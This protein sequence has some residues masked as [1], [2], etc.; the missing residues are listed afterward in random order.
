MPG[1]R[2]PY[3]TPYIVEP[4]RAIASGASKRIVMVFAAQTGKTEAMLDVAGHRLDQ[5]PGPI[6]YVGPNKQFL[7]EQFEPRVMALLDEAPTL[8]SKVARG[9][10]MTKTRKVI[11]GVP[12]RLAHAGSSTALKS[13]PAVLALIDEYDEM[14][15][16]VNQ[17]GGPLG[18]VERR[19]DTYAEFV[20]VVTSTPKKGRVEF[21]KDERSGLSFWDIAPTDDI[22]SPI[23]QLFQQGTRHHWCWPCPH[24]R[25]Y[26]VPRSALLRYPE[27]VTP[28]RAAKSAY[29]EC[30]N[31][32][33]EIFDRHK[34]GMNERGRYV[35]P[36]QKVDEDGNVTGSA[37]ETHLSYWVSGLATPFK[38]FGERVQV[39][40]EAKALG[41]DAMVQQAVNAGFGELHSSGGGVVSEWG[42]IK[43]K[44]KRSFYKRGRV[45]AGI[46]FLTMT[47]D[48]QRQSLIYT[49]RGWGPR[50]TS[51]LIEWGSIRGDTSDER[52]WSNELTDL[53]SSE[54][55]G[56]P[57]RL[58]LIDSGFRP[59]K[60]DILP[61]NRVYEFCRKFGRRVRPTKGASGSMRTPIIISK[62]EVNR[63]GE[64]AKYGLE[65][66][67]LDTDYFKSWV[68]ER[69]EWSEELPGAWHLPRDIDDD[70]CQQLVSE[71][72]VKK[73]NG[74]HEWVQR[75][76]HNH[77]LDCFDPETELL[78]SEGW[79][80]VANVTM[81][82]NVATVNLESDLIEYQKP[83]R[84]IA[85][86]HVGEMVRI[87]GRST[88]VLVT[89]NHRMITVRSNPVDEK[90]AMTLASDLSI[91]HRLKV[92]ATWKGKDEATVRFP[93]VP[94]DRQM[95]AQPALEIDAGDWAEFLGWY[96]SEGH[97]SA[98]GRSRVV[99]LT[100][101]PGPKADAIRSLLERMNLRYRIDGG[102]QYKVTSRQ[103][104]AMLEDCEMPGE[105]RGCYRKRAPR[106]IKEASPRLIERFIASAVLGDGWV[107]R[108]TRSYASVSKRLAD[109][110]QEL[111]IKIGRTATVK[112]RN[113]V[114]AV[115]HGRDVVNTVDQFHVTERYTAAT[116]L[117]DSRNKPLFSRIDYDGMVHCV[118]V[119]NGT[120]IARRNGKAIVVGNCEAMQ[121]AAGYL[122]NVQRIPL[123]KSENATMGGI[124]RKPLPPEKLEAETVEERAPP[125]KSKPRGVVRR[126]RRVSRSGY[127]S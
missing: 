83:Q 1:K 98:I 64:A 118:T 17:Q 16:N 10:R 14:K 82:M 112:R 87:S 48:V 84:L 117:R 106:W 20:C 73:P 70:Y 11:A 12:F 101:N 94:A 103:L 29:I 66:L 43:E 122:L 38:T 72:R 86:R 92:N 50:A 96:V 46:M 79:V 85:R 35:A 76:R 34:E 49:I 110:M 61:I 42:A 26:F 8:A 40:L 71:A 62:I 102:R 67:R 119:S 88:D 15:G 25:Q 124:G 125:P 123:P 45:P 126:G 91:W 113:A 120:L 37:A 58:T 32:G 111:F 97:R 127:F 7:S 90:P 80:P 99:T 55:E 13:D 95:A 60:K 59:G 21:V 107:Q 104:Y 65:L 19:G 27:N 24:C 31:C 33:C 56:M 44:G 116:L 100:Q 47:V 6:L 77:Y 68:H 36:G 52:I 2:D 69:L 93:A 78:T 18:L 28:M 30:P 39:Y 109:D 3:L 57:I 22:E 108:G 115:V 51:A 4:E 9:K 81:A 121:A 114:A 53:I 74:S 75:S 89:P 54:Y 63:K 5:K 41:D 23:W 105:G